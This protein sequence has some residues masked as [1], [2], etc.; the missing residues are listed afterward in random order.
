MWRCIGSAKMVNN[1]TYLVGESSVRVDGG[2]S[3]AV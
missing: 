3:E 1:R 2:V